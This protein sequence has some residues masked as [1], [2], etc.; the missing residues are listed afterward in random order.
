MYPAIKEIGT[1]LERKA[2]AT[3]PLGLNSNKS[4]SIKNKNQ[5]R[6]STYGEAYMESKSPFQESTLSSSP[7]C[8]SLTHELKV[9]PM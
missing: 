4:F 1:H 6:E 8:Y 2:R 3:T 7:L 9:V 5:L